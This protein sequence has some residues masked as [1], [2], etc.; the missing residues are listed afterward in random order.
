MSTRIFGSSGGGPSYVP[1]RVAW[2]GVRTR[3]PTTFFDRLGL[4]YRPQ[5]GI[6]QDEALQ[7]AGVP[8]GHVRVVPAVF[9]SA[10]LMKPRRAPPADELQERLGTLTSG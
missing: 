3:C 1:L 10:P 5:G 4:R 7:Q 8:A 6:R 2:R 9:C